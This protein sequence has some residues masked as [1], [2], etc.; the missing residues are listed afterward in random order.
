MDRMITVTVG[1]KSLAIVQLIYVQIMDVGPLQLLQQLQLRLPLQHF[2]Q[3][4]NVP[5]GNTIVV[6]ALA[7]GIKN[8]EQERVHHLV[9]LLNQV[10]C[11]EVR[12]VLIGKIEDV[13]KTTA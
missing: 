2:L 6:V 11:V 12:V 3:S 4:V 13:A 7:H 9:V 5:I 8:I 10:V 1:M